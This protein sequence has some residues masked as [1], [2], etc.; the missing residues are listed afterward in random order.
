MTGNYA[1]SCFGWFVLGGFPPGT[2]PIQSRQQLWVLLEHSAKLSLG[3]SSVREPI[4]GP[5]A[6]EYG[7]EVPERRLE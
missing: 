4:V 6:Q 7:N 1:S 5:A 2:T 3:I